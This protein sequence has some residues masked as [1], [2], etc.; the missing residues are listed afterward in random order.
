MSA[1]L[2]QA[3]AEGFVLG[4]GGYE[5]ELD[6]G[7][8]KMTL[9]LTHGST[10]AFKGYQSLEQFSAE[11]AVEFLEKTMP[12]EERDWSAENWAASTLKRAQLFGPIRILRYRGHW[13]GVGVTAELCPV[14]DGQTIAELSFKAD[15]WKAAAGTRERLM[16]FL[17]GHGILIHGDSLKTQAVLSACLLA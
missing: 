2:R 13:E 15:D 7:Y 11:D 10:G 8:A 3:E 9:S 1:A 17:D 14:G 6:W 4:A 12:G 5:A 16:A